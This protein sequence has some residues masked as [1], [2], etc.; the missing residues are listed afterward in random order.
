MF[1]ETKIKF[2]DLPDGGSH[3]FAETVQ[4]IKRQ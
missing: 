4:E 3:H 2:S 1:N